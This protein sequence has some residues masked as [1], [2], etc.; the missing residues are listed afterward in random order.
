MK[1]V[2]L[3]AVPELHGWEK[4]GDGVSAW[5]SVAQGTGL[6]SSS[7]FGLVQSCLLLAVGINRQVKI[8]VALF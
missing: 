3:T 8:C 2:P 1:R 7:G 4:A 6:S 5:P